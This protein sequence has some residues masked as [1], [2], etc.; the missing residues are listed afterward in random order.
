MFPNDAR[1]RNLTYTAPL[2][3]DVHKSVES[4]DMASP[5]N[6][7]AR[8]PLD[9]V[10]TR[11]DADSD[12]V[13]DGVPVAAKV[14]LGRIPVMLRSR[15]CKLYALAAHDV[16]NLNECPFDQGGYF[17]ING[18]EKV[19]IAQ[20]RMATN[21]V[22]VFAKAPPSKFAFTAEINSA[23]DKS[24][25]TASGLMIKMLSKGEGKHAG[26]PIRA[27]LPYIRGDVPIVVVFRAMGILSDKDIL[28]HI[29]FDL[30]DFQMLELLKPSIEEA[31]PIQDMSVALD[32][33]GRRGNA[34]AVSKEKRIKYGVTL[35]LVP[36]L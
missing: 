17:I 5:E 2:Y 12:A 22:Y 25:R 6:A 9:Y 26:Q 3:V 23:V 35:S 10:W 13:V 8:S 21:Q 18:S 28:E 34:I 19:I 1:L 31:F 14:F 33:I 4:A 16:A 15:Y 32:Y 27:S 11:D 30:N 20:E 29:C 7:V 36:A 24:S